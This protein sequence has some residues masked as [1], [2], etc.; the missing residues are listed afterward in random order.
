[1]K[2]ES[3]V[4][5]YS[6]L[7]ASALS[8]GACGDSTPED[9]GG[10]ADAGGGGADAGGGGQAAGACADVKPYSE[11]GSVFA[12][13]TNCHSATLVTPTDR[14]AAPLG[15]DYDTYEAATAHPAETR[16]VVE[17][18]AAPIPPT[19]LTPTEKSA[20]LLWIDCDMPE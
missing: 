9:G 3:R 17:S 8:A 11:L 14:Q 4:F 15:F 7:L 16:S 20:L 12:K 5:V 6:I 18:G 10:G 1:M 13:C 2:F 19:T